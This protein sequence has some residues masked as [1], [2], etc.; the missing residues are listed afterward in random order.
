MAN[1]IQHDIRHKLNEYRFSIYLFTQFLILFGSLFIPYELYDTYISPILLVVN[2]IAGLFIIP[3]R[4]HFRKVF[5]L[6]VAIL[7]CEFVLELMGYMPFKTGIYLRFFSYF[8]VYVGITY[9]LIQQIWRAKEVDTAMIM[10]LISGYISLGLIGFF[11]LSTVYMVEPESFKGIHNAIDSETQSPMSKLLYFSFIT[12]LTIGY[13]DIAPTMPISQKASMV[14]G[15][16]G[17]L[18]LV[19]ITSITVGKYIGQFNSNKG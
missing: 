2:L 13:G 15:L 6:S 16:M 10:G 19:I 12:L 8:I 5:Y 14:I 9:H 11:M 3:L 4:S 7:V 1:Q 18:Y 17:Q